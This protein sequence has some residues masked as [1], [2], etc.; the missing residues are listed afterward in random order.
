MAIA[1]CTV[2]SCL[3][4]Q[5]TSAEDPNF[6]RA[7][8]NL[9]DNTCDLRVEFVKRMMEVKSKRIWDDEKLTDVKDRDDSPSMN[10]DD[11]KGE[12][13]I[14]DYI[15]P[16]GIIR[17]PVNKH[18]KS[19][20]AM[21]VRQKNEEKSSYVRS[22]QKKLCRVLSLCDQMSTVNIDITK[23]QD[24]YG[25]SYIELKINEDARALLNATSI[26]FELQIEIDN[27]Q[28]V[29]KRFSLNCPAKRQKR[30]SSFR[31]YTSWGTWSYR[32][33][34]HR[35]YF[36]FYQQ[37]KRKLGWRT[38]N[39]GSGAVVWAMIFGYYDRRSHYRT[40]VYGN[41][42]QP[43]YACSY[44]GVFGRQNCVAPRLTTTS[45]IRNYIHKISREISTACSYGAGATPARW[46]DHV[47]GFFQA[48]QKSGN[49]TIRQTNDIWNKVANKNYASQARAWIR[50]GWPVVVSTHEGFFNTPYAVAIRYR[51]K[52][53]RWRRCLKFTPFPKFCLRWHTNS[54]YQMY[55]RQG[56]GRG[57][58]KWRSMKIHY[59]AVA[60]Y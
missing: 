29:R 4:S 19:I 57:V 50:S 55:V 33:I 30:G 16:G 39:V 60:S 34:G 51:A 37:F 54:R 48:R 36:P 9:M 10:E 2:Q 56:W 15:T 44:N 42:S 38:C 22:M 35:G 23:T 32:S 14:E 41:G 25:Y 6:E 26:D 52:H 24:L 17:L 20:R 49:P 27:K 40:S 7:H 11:D 46:M 12:G 13:F 45:R 59:A 8:A 53:R 5:M 21:Y 43:L 3:Y 58:V 28:L 18:T 1:E 47:K 31:E